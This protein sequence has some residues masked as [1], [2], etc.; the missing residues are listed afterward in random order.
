MSDLCKRLEEAAIKSLPPDG[1][2]YDFLGVEDTLEGEAIAEISRLRA[3]R[4][5]LLKAVN[6][7][8]GRF[9][10]ASPADFDAAEKVIAEVELETTA[11]SSGPPGGSGGA[12]NSYSTVTYASGGALDDKKTVL[13]EDERER[14]SG[15]VR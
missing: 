2:E 13:D 6:L 11:A 8:Q 3:Q 7:F 12:G 10:A 14:L 4:D 1:H 9:G 15:E 5:G